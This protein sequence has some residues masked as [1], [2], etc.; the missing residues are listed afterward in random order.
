M[1]GEKDCSKIVIDEI[2]SVPIT[3]FLIPLKLH[4]LVLGFVLNRIFDIVKPPP[5]NQAQMLRGGW[6]VVLDDVVAGIYSNLVML[7][8]VY[9]FCR[10]GSMG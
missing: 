8:T 4:F 2:V 10:F 6:G 1:D 9:L 5:A 7:L 3:M